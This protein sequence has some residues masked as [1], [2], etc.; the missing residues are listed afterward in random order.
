MA[1][2]CALRLP[3]LGR[4]GCC[5]LIPPS[6]SSL[7]PSRAQAYTEP[8]RQPC[9]VIS[10]NHHWKK[11]CNRQT[12]LIL[13]E[14][15]QIQNET[16]QTG[17]ISSSSSNLGPQHKGTWG[18]GLSFWIVRRRFQRSGCCEIRFTGDNNRSCNYMCC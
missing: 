14:L 18:R 12:G 5:C 17:L 8:Q 15:A 6:S 3:R 10:K 1:Q 13:Y 16:K 4:P 11:P 7:L 9:Q 2:V